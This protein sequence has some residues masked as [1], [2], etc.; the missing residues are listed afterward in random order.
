MVRPK[1]RAQ[2]QPPAARRK[3]VVNRQLRRIGS[4]RTKLPRD[5][6]AGVTRAT[7][8]IWRTEW[9]QRTMLKSPAITT[10]PSSPAKI[11]SSSATWSCWR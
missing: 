8:A 11:G 1:L 3:G 9:A 7:V 6:P 10:D 4:K 2:F 5:G